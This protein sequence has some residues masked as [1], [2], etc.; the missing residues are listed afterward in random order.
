M[1]ISVWLTKYPIKKF[2]GMLI[3]ELQIKSI[4]VVNISLTGYTTSAANSN[5][6]GTMAKFTNPKTPTSSVT[7]VLFG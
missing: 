4:P 5:V 2:I 3:S 1:Y 6:K 7:K